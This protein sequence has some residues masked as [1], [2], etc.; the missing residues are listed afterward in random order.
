MNFDSLYSKLV[1]IDQRFFPNAARIKM[2]NSHIKKKDY[3]V[4]FQPTRAQ[5]YGRHPDIVAHI[6]NVKENVEGL[7][8]TPDLLASD[9]GC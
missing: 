8:M 5:R 9:H 2:N 6:W 7:D 3:E 4:Y 1:L